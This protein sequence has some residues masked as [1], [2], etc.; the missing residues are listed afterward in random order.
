MLQTD[1]VNTVYLIGQSERNTSSTYLYHFGGLLLN[2]TPQAESRVASGR[3]LQ[4]HRS[5]DPVLGGELSFNANALSFSPGSQRSPTRWACRNYRFQ[6][7]AGR[8]HRLAPPA[9]R[10]DRADLHAVLPCCAATSIQFKDMVDPV[11]GSDRRTIVTRGLATAGLPYSY[12]WVAQHRRRDPRHRAGRPDHRTAGQCNQRTCRTRTASL[13]GRHQSVR[14]R[15]VC[16]ASTGSRPEHGSTT[17]CSTPSRL[18]RRLGARCSPA[19]ATTCRATTST[20]IPGYDPD[21]RPNYLPLSGLETSVRT[22]CWAYTCRRRRC[23]A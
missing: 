23:S 11:T 8:R 13:F 16:P 7:A 15:Q 12:P 17:A 10:S 4:L 3:R 21:G 5:A 19:R 20:A 6:R 2:D 18:Q 14:G 22:T 9:D 1:R